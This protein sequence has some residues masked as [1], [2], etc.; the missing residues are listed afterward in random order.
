MKSL[1]FFTL[2]FFLAFNEPSWAGNWL[3]CKKQQVRNA[4]I[5][6]SKYENQGQ[7]NSKAE[8]KDNPKPESANTVQKIEQNDQK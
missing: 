7:N 4:K 8:Q 3:N 6:C 2:I 5:D 1:F